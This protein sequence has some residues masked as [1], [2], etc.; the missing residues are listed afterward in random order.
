MSFLSLRHHH[1]GVEGAEQGLLVPQPRVREGELPP[2]PRDLAHPA[3]LRRGRE[4][5]RGPEEDLHREQDVRGHDQDLLQVQD[6][7]HQA[8]S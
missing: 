6:A 7:L 2:L 5:R 4:R 8:G 3:S 1:G